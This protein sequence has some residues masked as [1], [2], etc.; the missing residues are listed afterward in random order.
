MECHGSI[1]PGLAAAL[2]FEELEVHL[3][4]ST[5]PHGPTRLRGEQVLRDLH[6]R[7]PR[8][9]EVALVKIVRRPSALSTAIHSSS[10]GLSFEYIMQWRRPIH[11][12]CR[13]GPPPS[14]TVRPALPHPSRASTSSV[15]PV[16]HP[17]RSQGPTSGACR[18]RRFCTPSSA[19]TSR[20]SSMTP[21]LGMSRVLD[22]HASSSRSSA[23]PQPAPRRTVCAGAGRATC[24]QA[25]AAANGRGHSALD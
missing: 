2:E 17:D 21:A 23:A 12:L 6:P 3:V 25:V 7:L 14:V 22:T 1:H 4:F 8:F 11:P 24:V 19:T 9:S 20:P 15:S 13:M 10:I 16:P 5:L 18:R